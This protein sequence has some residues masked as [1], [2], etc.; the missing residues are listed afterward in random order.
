VQEALDNAHG[1]HVE[2]LVVHVCDVLRLEL[3]DG[4]LLEGQA[5]L[6]EVDEIGTLGILQ[7]CQQA[8]PLV[9]VERPPEVG[10]VHQC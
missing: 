7:D 4:Q 9:G 2:H 6:R 10:L 1:L 8:L 3:E 5:E